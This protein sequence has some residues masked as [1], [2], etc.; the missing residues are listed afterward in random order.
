[1]ENEKRY[2]RLSAVHVTPDDL[3]SIAA[4]EGTLRTLQRGTRHRPDQVPISWAG[5]EGEPGAGH[6]TVW[7][8]VAGQDGNQLAGVEAGTCAVILEAGEAHVMM[9]VPQAADTTVPGRAAPGILVDLSWSLDSG[10]HG[11]L[12]EYLGRVLEQGVVRTLEEEHARAVRNA[13]TARTRI[14]AE[15]R[16][17]GTD[18]EAAR[19]LAG[20]GADAGTR[21]WQTWRKVSQERLDALAAGMDALVRWFRTHEMDRDAAEKAERETEAAAGERE[22]ARPGTERQGPSPRRAPGAAALAATQL[23]ARGLRERSRKGG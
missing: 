7:K 6:L 11:D 12:R 10:E 22:A 23:V 4:A 20:T 15:D 1:M 21:T 16:G 13:A 17:G 5:E 18:A 9:A 3:A 19:T 14:R 8:P 2:P